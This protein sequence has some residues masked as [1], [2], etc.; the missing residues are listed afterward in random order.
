MSGVPFSPL[1]V[2]TQQTGW[3]L[4][5][6]SRRDVVTGLAA[7]AALSG[8]APSAAAGARSV[9]AIAFDAFPIFDPRPIT[10]LARS[11]VGEQGDL[12]ASAWSIRLFGYTWLST[13]ARRYQDFASL[14]DA[15]LN[16][17]AQ[18]L[19]VTLSVKD[20][21][22]LSAAYTE[23]NLWPDVKPALARLK[24]AGVRLVILS[25]LSEMTLRANL[26]RAGI[27]GLF[28]AVL[29]TDRVRQFKPSP[30]AYQMAMDKL[31]LA[32][33]DIG[34]AAFAGW[35]AVG[36]SWFGYRTAWINRASAPPEGLDGRVAI[37]SRDI[38]GALALAGLT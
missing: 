29:S 33:A 36:A 20:R 34:F 21:A 30:D 38:G 18:S 2:P 9:R 7:S 37:V 19:G 25:N 26:N 27:D 23:M 16:A 13:A 22:Q 5:L 3:E 24:E 28:D 4:P 8:S 32:K 31:G 11:L 35:D 17:S 1:T 15:A 12:L 6:A 14:A 10:A